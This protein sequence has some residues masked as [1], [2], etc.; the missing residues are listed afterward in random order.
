M[1]HAATIETTPT[2]RMRVLMAWF[3]DNLQGQ[4][5]LTSV[6]PSTR[7]R[8]VV[9]MPTHEIQQFHLKILDVVPGMCVT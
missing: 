8:L 4:G 9:I 6:L 3:H 2:G 7:R 1:N 5:T